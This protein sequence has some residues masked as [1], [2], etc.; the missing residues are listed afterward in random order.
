MIAKIPKLIKEQKEPK[1]KDRRQAQL[2]AK[3]V[4]PVS[5]TLFFLV[6][7]MSIVIGVVLDAT[8]EVQDWVVAAVIIG[9]SLIGVYLL[10]A[11]KIADQWEKAIVLRLGRFRSLKGPGLFW[12][13]P[14]V[15]LEDLYFFTEHSSLCV[16]FLH[17]KCY[18]VEDVVAHL[19]LVS[20]EWAGS[21]KI[22][23][24][25]FPRALNGKQH[26]EQDN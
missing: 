12:I 4:N 16:P 18:A 24:V 8:T 23:E 9:G 11:L 14:V 26:A 1:E 25:L 17:G 22:D 21:A 13:V 7:A 2:E 19:C 20:S 3:L 15:S 10:F 6:L 5:L